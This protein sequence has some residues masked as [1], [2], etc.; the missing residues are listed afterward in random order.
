LIVAADSVDPKCRQVAALPW[1]VDANG[2]VSVL[3]I[4]SRNNGK[5]MLPK[6]WPIDGK[7]DAQ[8]AAQEAFEEAGVRGKVGEH[9]VGSYAYIK[10]FD[11]GSTKPSQA[12]VFSLRVSKLLRDWREKGER[13]RKWFRAAKAAQV[14]HEADLGR[15]L[16]NL[17][18]GRIV[19]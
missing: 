2:M 12:V 9:P 8:S 4:T 18:A 10:L 19:L 5:W 3:L 1:R 7:S 6:G 17:G 15:F 13:K 14:V 11:D 16:A